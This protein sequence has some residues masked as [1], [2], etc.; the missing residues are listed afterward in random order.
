MS[1]FS[2][3]FEDDEQFQST[4][5]SQSS[6][7]S[8]N[9]T[10]NVLDGSVPTSSASTKKRRNLPGNP[11]KQTCFILLSTYIAA[12][13]LRHSCITILAAF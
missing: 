8:P 12:I 11:G 3:E 6:Y 1:N 10:E 13:H 7:G 5:V 9:P 2:Q 4:I